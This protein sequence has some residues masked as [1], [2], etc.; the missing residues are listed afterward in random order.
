MTENSCFGMD[1]KEGCSTQLFSKAM[2]LAF[3]LGSTPKECHCLFLRKE[4]NAPDPAPK[5]KNFFDPLQCRSN[6]T[7]FFFNCNMCKFFWRVT[8][9]SNHSSLIS[10]YPFVINLIILTSTISYYSIINFFS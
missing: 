8:N 2:D 7:A 4:T 5:S 3:G 9:L 6:K 10:H 1:S